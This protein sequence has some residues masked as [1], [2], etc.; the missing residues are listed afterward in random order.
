[1]SDGQIQT[2][3]HG[4][5][6]VISFDRPDRKNAFTQAM[7]TQLNAALDAASAEKT[8]RAVLFTGEG[9]AFSA[10]N[11]LM[12]FMHN[13]PTGTDSPVFGL[14]SRL[15]DFEKPMVAAVNG[16]AIGIGTTLLLHCDLA[17]AAE[18][19]T[20]KM[21]FVP[22]GLVPEAGSSMI[23]PMMVGH[24]KAAEL[25]M[26]GEKFDAATAERLNLLNAVV[27]PDALLETA[28]AKA[29][30][31]AALPP[32][33]VRQTKALMRFSQREALKAVMVK[34]GGVFVERLSSPETAEAI[35]AFFERRAPD[36]SKFE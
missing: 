14:L 2:R 28:M 8:V 15:V 36:F 20:F 5:V 17:Y 11:D 30:A 6:R 35:Q 23:I 16:A 7:Y 9:D 27:A 21:P 32:G 12:D 1:M 18:H 13:P 29:T 25:L 24:V 10:G 22:L 19:A 26:L 3:D 4:A 34:E 33:A 31:L